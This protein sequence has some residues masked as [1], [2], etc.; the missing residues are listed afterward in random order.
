MSASGYNMP[1]YCR[2]QDR[3]PLRDGPLYRKKQRPGPWPM[4]LN[5]RLHAADAKYHTER[6][7]EAALA[8]G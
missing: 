3:L 7:I 4:N 1:A 5:R 8:A 6:F 2:F